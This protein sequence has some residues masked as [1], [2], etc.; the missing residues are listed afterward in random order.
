[1]ASG[2]GGGRNWTWRGESIGAI[3]DLGLMLPIAASLVVANGFAPQRL[4]FL[5]GLAYIVSAARYRLPISIQPLKA[6]AVI[7]LAQALDAAF[8]GTA[9]FVYGVVMLAIG[10]S[11]AVGCLRKWIGP[12]IVS[13]IQLGI[14]LI[15]G[16]RALQFLAS[17]DLWLP[18]M[19]TAGVPH[20]VFP[21]SWSAPN[22]DAM[23]AAF[24]L[25]VLPQLPLTLG[26]AVIAA[27]ATCRQ[28]W[29][30]GSGRI[31]AARLARSIGWLNLVIGLCGGF[32]V[33][34]GAGGIAA[35]ARFGAR[36][37]RSTTLLGVG[38]CTLALTPGGTDWLFRLPLPAL[39]LMLLLA[40][41]KMA[42]LGWRSG[43]LRSRA[44]AVPVGLTGLV[45][46]NLAI[47]L[48]IGVVLQNVLG[49]RRRGV[50][51]GSRLWRGKAV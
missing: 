20:G 30:E 2:E 34:H 37:W 14:G 43:D 41:V 4:F 38:L 11:G 29:P 23:A 7:A 42:G 13:G 17:G 10:M 21:I 40:A 31:S 18:T 6:M 22:A 45:S 27:E 50:A 39:A 28:C 49:E 15:L 24:V 5:W 9:A 12:A 3:G 36:T 1:M 33:C 48:V 51:R 44:V 35:H 47:A 25:L 16:R 46:G 8:I 26:N 19:R 32:P